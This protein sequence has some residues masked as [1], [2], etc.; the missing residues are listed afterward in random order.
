[1]KIIFEEGYVFCRGEGTWSAE[2][3]DKALKVASGLLDLIEQRA[4]QEAGGDRPGSHF[5]ST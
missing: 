2:E 5:T 4:G 3:Y 1:M